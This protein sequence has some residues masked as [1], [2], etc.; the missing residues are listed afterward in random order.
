MRCCPSAVST[1]VS[2]PGRGQKQGC[3]TTY[4]RILAR[5]GPTAQYVRQ[6]VTGPAYPRPCGANCRPKKTVVTTKG[7]S[8]PVRGQLLQLGRGGRN[9]GRIPARAGPTFWAQASLTVSMAYPRPCGANRGDRAGVREGGA[10]PRPGGAN[11]CPS[12]CSCAV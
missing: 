8:P 3:H 6:Q 5:A 11:Q 10:Y 12:R 4:G 1:G 7:V 2:P 9:R